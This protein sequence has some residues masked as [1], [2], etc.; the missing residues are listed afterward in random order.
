MFVRRHHERLGLNSARTNRNRFAN[1]RHALNTLAAESLEERIV[2]NAA[3][4]DV[5]A[6]LNGGVLSIIGDEDPNGIVLR[7]MEKSLDDTFDVTGGTTSVFLDPT[8]LASVG[9]TVSSIDSTGTPFS[10]EF[11]VGFPIEP[12]TDFRFELNGSFAPVSGQIEHSGTVGFLADTIIAGNFVVGF[13]AGRIS[14]DASGFFVEDTNSALGILFDISNPGIVEV[15]NGDFTLADADLLLS[16]EFATAL[17]NP[18]AAGDD[19][20]NVR[21]DAEVSE[22]TEEF[23]K[24]FGTRVLG[25]RTHI[26]GER[27]DKFPAGDV[28]EI[29]VETAG[30][31]D[32]V[33]AFG[34]DFGGPLSIHTGE[35]LRD[36][37]FI[38][39]SNLGG[40]TSIY[41]G[42][43]ADTI[44]VWRSELAALMINTA[45]GNDRVNIVAA[46]L[47]SLNISGAPTQNAINGVGGALFQSVYLWDV[48]VSGVVDIGLQANQ[49]STSII[50]STLDG[51]NL[52]TY[53]GSDFVNI[54]RS[55]ILFDAEINL[56]GGNDR[57]FVLNTDIGGD[58]FFD[59][60][61]GIRDLFFSRFSEYGL[62]DDENFE[63]TN[64]IPPL[65]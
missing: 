54:Q 57:L 8:A 29:E 9:L 25:H 52:N 17:F 26:N 53:D 40:E 60:G 56:F 18:G 43:T 3:G 20:G 16:T 24:V 42:S 12:T 2:L 10:N 51:L 33:V 49:T 47:E 14:G 1:S 32:V 5:T 63:L 23:I 64:I 38:G 62:L 27:F 19:V 4:T 6:E 58:A 44:S 34:L 61:D 15:N 7:S 45:G 39:H 59:G 41:G 36:N 46:T 21:I 22:V 35:G 31:S 50:E 11:D 48:T 65:P 55:D 13:D 37:V 30:G 28:T